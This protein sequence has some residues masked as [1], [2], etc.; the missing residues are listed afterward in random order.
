MPENLSKRPRLLIV[1]D[2]FLRQK[3]SQWMAFGP[4]VREVEN[5]ASLFSVI[6]WIGLDPIGEDSPKTLLPIKHS[7]VRPIALKSKRG[8]SFRGKVLALRFLCSTLPTLLRELAKHDVIHSRAPSVPALLAALASFVYRRPIY[9]HKYAGDWIQEPAPL[10]YGLQRSLLKQL[11]HTRV[12]I[13]GNWSDQPAHCLSFENPCL[14]ETE[15]LDGH[16]TIAKKDYSGLLEF[17]FV[18]RLEQAKGVDRILD[19]FSRLKDTSRIKS[20]HFVGDGP[21][22]EKYEQ[23][24]S[25][26]DLNIVFHGFMERENLP[27]VL[28]RS[29]ILLLPS[30]SEGFPK[31]IAEGANYGCIPIAT[32]V[33][34]IGQYVNETNGWILDPKN[35]EGPELAKTLEDVISCDKLQHKANAAHKM[36]TSFTF[37]HY[38]KRIQQ[39]IL[40]RAM[41]SKIAEL[42]EQIDS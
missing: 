5:F 39:D 28:A 20:L 18:G 25:K 4:V 31:V 32:N 26:I 41:P 16:S 24:A 33:G 3:E 21:N 12:T 29:H 1:S 10:S 23:L 7:R 9:W 19:A 27:K 2:T 34:S 13:N 37:E 42:K 36:V 38:N 8:K 15:S 40:G 22:R 11:R 14:D 6:T 30:F 17:C 35:C